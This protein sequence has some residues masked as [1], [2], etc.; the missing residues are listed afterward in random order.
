M[1][2]TYINEILGQVA[3]ENKCTLEHVRSE[4]EA[5][6]DECWNNPDPEIHAEWV[7]MSASGGRPTIEEVIISIS[8]QVIYSEEQ[9]RS[10][11]WHVPWV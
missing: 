2:E 3:R 7:A 9:V 10:R 5:L 4:I 11:Y 6:I 8:A 1:K